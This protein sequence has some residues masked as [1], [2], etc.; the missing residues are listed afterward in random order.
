[1]SITMRCIMTDPEIQPLRLIAHWKYDP[2]S[3]HFIL[4][5]ALGLNEPEWAGVGS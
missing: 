4:E 3:T 1:M 5:E 2:P